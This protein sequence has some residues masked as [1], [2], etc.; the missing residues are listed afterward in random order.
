M[1]KLTLKNE[2]LEMTISELLEGWAREKQI[3][4]EMLQ[5]CRRK[6]QA[7]Q[8]R[9]QHSPEILKKAVEKAQ[10]E[11]Q[12]FSLIEKGV[13]TEEAR[14]LCRVLVHAGCSQEL[15]GSVIDEVL[16]AAGIS[17]VGSKMSQRTVA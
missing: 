14:E 12:K 13:Y 1:S 4:N 8:E 16:A 15:V 11:R 3:A 10:V 7:L 2:Q 17:V 5:E 6:I 9:C